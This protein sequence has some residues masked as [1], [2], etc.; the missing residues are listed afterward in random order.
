VFFFSKVRI[1]CNLYE[2]SEGDE[3]VHF[4]VLKVCENNCWFLLFSWFSSSHGCYFVS[5]C[6][7]MLGVEDVRLVCNFFVVIVVIV[8]KINQKSARSMTWGWFFFMGGGWQGNGRVFCAGGDLRMFYN[9]Q[10][11]AAGNADFVLVQLLLLMFFSLCLSVLDSLSLSQLFW[12]SA[13]SMLIKDD[14]ALLFK[15]PLIDF[16]REIKFPFWVEI[17]RKFFWGNVAD[18][19]STTE[20]VYSKYWLDYHAAT[21]KKP[22]VSC[23]SVCLFVCVR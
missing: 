19:P 3:N 22:L 16:Q 13:S 2:Q 23:L 5:V 15:Q 20:V 6:E 10:K 17:T 9:A 18:D 7:V 4:L 14:A 8:G 11:A 21:Y 12:T 1:L